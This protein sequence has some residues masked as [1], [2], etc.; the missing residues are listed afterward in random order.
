MMTFTNEQEIGF[1]QQE[2]IGIEVQIAKLKQ[3]KRV[4][5]KIADNEM[6][7]KAVNEMTRLAK[8]VDAYNEIIEE[9]KK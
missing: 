4:G 1:A 5:E 8:M 7:T 9:I 3:M 6:V 2:I